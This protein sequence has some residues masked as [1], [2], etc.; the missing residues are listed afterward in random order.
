MGLAA[1]TQKKHDN[2]PSPQEL[3]QTIVDDRIWLGV[4]EE[5]LLHDSFTNEK[6]F[7]LNSPR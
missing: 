6:Y 1:S 2:E 3:S 7:A 4:T 5:N